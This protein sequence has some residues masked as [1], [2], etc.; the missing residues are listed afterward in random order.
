MSGKNII[1]DDKKI[2]KSNFHENKKLFNINDIKVD[3]ILTSKTEPYVKKKLIKIL[4]WMF[5]YR[6][7]RRKLSQ[8]IGYAKDFDSNKTMSF[9]V[10]DC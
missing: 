7:L 9:K 6:S 1:F 4:Y 3:K 2:N 8:M 5:T 10:N